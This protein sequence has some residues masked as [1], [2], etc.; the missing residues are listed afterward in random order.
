MR[1]FEKVEAKITEFENALTGYHGKFIRGLVIFFSLF[2]IISGWLYFV[3]D[4]VAVYLSAY[5][6][7]YGTPGNSIDLAYAIVYFLAGQAAAFMSLLLIIPRYD[8]AMRDVNRKNLLKELEKVRDAMLGRYTE[9]GVYKA[10][11]KAIKKKAE[12][13]VFLLK[14]RFAF[15]ILISFVFTLIVFLII[16]IGRGLEKPADFAMILMYLNT[17]CILG[18]LVIMIKRP[19]HKTEIRVEVL[20]WLVSESEADI[21]S[22]GFQVEG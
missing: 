4:I 9:Q 18:L 13:P 19:K 17:C 12:T 21:V 11:D 3:N 16:G 14:Y 6:K 10:L 20:T 8:F 7:N 15:F 1:T 5:V 22:Q 2:V